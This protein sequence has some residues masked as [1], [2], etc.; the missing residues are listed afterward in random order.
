M[1][2]VDVLLMCYDSSDSES[3]GYIA[4]LRVNRDF[5]SE[6][7]CK[8]KYPILDTIAQ[9]WAATKADLDRIQ[10]RHETQPDALA[11]QLQL[12]PP[13]HISSITAWTGADL[14]VQISEAAQWPS[15][16]TPRKQDQRDLQYSKFRIAR[17]VSFFTVSAT[18]LY[19]WRRSRFSLLHFFRF[20]R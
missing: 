17:Y 2:K 3:F 8:S 13:L 14:F 10:Q 6:S 5:K 7:N 18:V 12:P 19:L 20:N 11:R 15:I 16:S 1:D 9:V 4:E